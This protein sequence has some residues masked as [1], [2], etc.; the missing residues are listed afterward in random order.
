MATKKISELPLITELSG[1]NEGTSVIPV[2]V[3]GTTDQISIEDFSKFVNRYNATTASNNFIGN[4]TVNGNV[5]VTGKITAEEFHTEITSASIIYQSGSTQFGNDAGDTHTFLG[6]L[7]VNGQTIGTTQLNAQTASQDLVNR[8]IGSVTGSLN[9]QTGSQSNLNIQIGIATSSLNFATRSLNIQTGSQDLV[10]FRI[11]ST[12]GSINT[13][14]S[15]FNLEFNKIGSTTASIHFTTGALNAFTGSVIGQTNTISTFTSSVNF[16]TQSLNTQTGSQDLVNFRI[17]STTG[18]INTTTSSFDLV[19]RAI[20]SVTGAM[21]TQSS[22]QDLVNYQ[23]S[24]VTSSFR[25]EIGGI[26][27][28]TASLKN[29]IIV[30]GSNVQ[31]VGELDVARLNVQYVS[32]SVSYNSGSNIFGDASADK[33]EFSGSVNIQDTLFIKGQAIGTGELNAFTASQISKDGTLAIVTSS[34]RAEIGGIEAYTASLKGATLISSSN[35]IFVN[36]AVI[37]DNTSQKILGTSGNILYLYTGTSGLYINNSANNAQNVTITDVGVV[38][39]R[40]GLQIGSSGN[41]QNLTFGGTNSSIYWGVGGPARMYYST[42]DIRI[43]SNG[44]SDV[45]NVKNIG[46]ILVSG[47]ITGSL[48]ATNGVVSGSTQI[49][50]YNVFALTASANTFW[51]TQTFSGSFNLSG[52]MNQSGAST[53]IGNT[54]LSGSIAMSGS[55]VQTGNNTLIGNTV[56]SGSIEVSGSSNFRNSLFILSGSTFFTGS[57]DVKGNSSFTGSMSV[58]GN[59]TL[60][61]SINIAS[62]S[63]FYR[64]GNKLFNYGQFFNTQTQSGS[65]DTAYPMEY[66]TLDFADGVNITNNLSGLPTRITVTNTG[67]YNLQFSSQLGTTATE[68]VD[69]TIWLVKNGT[70]V[71][72]SAGEIGIIKDAG[73]GKTLAAWNYMVQL[74]AGE[75]VELYYSKT[76]A[77]GQI[78]YLGTQT[79]PTRPASASTIITITQVA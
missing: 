20:S 50:N 52:S 59:T 67:V 77:N 58:T 62:G 15:S 23:N 18:S 38:T 49:Q 1:S 78:Q 30:N 79:T 32:S 34:L 57:H 25:N 21:N 11:A 75:Y 36:G 13:T 71:S 76:T 39:T 66:N 43:S 65:A 40:G 31:I 56:L 44:A 45:L 54:V 63:G 22:S 73:G 7:T 51:G 69:F 46:G 16:A 68:S 4:Q 8:T 42:G 12:T 26:G 19:F 9:T 35:Q 33:H 24:I 37:S 47:G 72:N 2:V 28:Y 60:S 5:T 55:T 61:G 74:N 41:D 27:A 14:T 17:A 64:A 6:T 53:L 70:A 10:N 48:M 3:G 29:A